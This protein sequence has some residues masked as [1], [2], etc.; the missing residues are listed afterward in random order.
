MSTGSWPRSRTTRMTANGTTMTR[1]WRT[2]RGTATLASTIRIRL[3]AR[4]PMLPVATS[5]EKAKMPGKEGPMGLER[6]YLPSLY[7][8]QR[9]PEQGVFVL[10]WASSTAT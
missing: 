7:Y 1:P 5:E 6:R 2:S 9:P 3:A 4:G 10:E 8:F